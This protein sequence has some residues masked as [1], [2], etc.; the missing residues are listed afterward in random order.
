MPGLHVA[1]CTTVS[2]WYRY[3]M[4]KCGS[5]CCLKACVGGVSELQGTLTAC[6]PK[7]WCAHM[8][9]RSHALRITTVM[10]HAWVA[11]W[12]CECSVAL[13]ELRGQYNTLIS[14][15]LPRYII[16]AVQ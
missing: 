5:N 8:A 12:L 9:L 15:C 7:F 2:Y 14:H 16:K 11:G 6:L 3:I 4:K 1:L 10:P 13:M